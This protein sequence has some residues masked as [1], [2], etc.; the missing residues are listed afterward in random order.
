M[1]SLN[2]K[3]VAKKVSETIRKGK[4]VNL[5]DIIENN[6][7]SKSTSK[8]PTI[9]TKTK[10]FQEEIKPLADG[11]DREIERIKVEMASRDITEE[12]YKDL[13]DVLDK[14][15]KQYQLLTGGKTE[16]GGIEEL[17]KMLNSWINNK[18]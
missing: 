15:V 17:T 3:L 13:A 14:L 6:G 11:I 8:S 4:R 16:N 1:G 5:G 18:K 10:S 9:V 2:A 7:Y 12:K